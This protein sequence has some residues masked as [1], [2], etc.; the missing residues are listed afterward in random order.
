M[1]NLK[2]LADVNKYDGVVSEDLQVVITAAADYDEAL[3]DEY[4]YAILARGQLKP[5]HK[6]RKSAATP[7]ASAKVPKSREFI[8]DDESA[9]EES[10]DLKSDKSDHQAVTPATPTDELDEV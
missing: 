6:P 10:A 7:R 8:A 2:W 1:A 4:Y 3:A 5:T 9:G